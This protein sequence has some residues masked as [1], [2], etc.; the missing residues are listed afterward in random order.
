[1]MKFLWALLILVL[2][3]LWLSGHWFGR[4]LMLTALAG[5]GV[6]LLVAAQRQGPQ[7][8]GAVMIL[9]SWPIASAPAWVWARLRGP[10]DWRGRV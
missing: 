8:F 4:G 10:H 7:I 5:L 9:A 1:M 6:F 3:W 2:L